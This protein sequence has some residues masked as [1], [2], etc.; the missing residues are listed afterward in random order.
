MDPG[1]SAAQDVSFIAEWKH[2]LCCCGN[3]QHQGNNQREKKKTARS[4]AVNSNS[5]SL[6]WGVE[7]NADM[8]GLPVSAF[9]PLV[10]PTQ[11]FGDPW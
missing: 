11:P 8:N 10:I 9:I 3:I 2:L 1:H 7:E 4:T 5:L 6:S